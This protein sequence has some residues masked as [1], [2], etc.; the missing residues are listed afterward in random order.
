MGDGNFKPTRSFH[1]GFHDDDGDMLLIEGDSGFYLPGGIMR[2]SDLS[3]FSGDERCIGLFIAKKMKEQAEYSLPINIQSMPA[4][5]NAYSRGR[6]AAF[7]VEYSAVLVGKIDSREVKNPKAAF[8][9]IDELIEIGEGMEINR[10]QYLLA[11][12]MFASRDWLGFPYTRNLAGE[13]LQK[14]HQ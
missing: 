3:C 13:T 11:L 12:R 5:Y 7:H 8:F 6:R 9:T 1:G 10:S 14:K 2:W 4:F